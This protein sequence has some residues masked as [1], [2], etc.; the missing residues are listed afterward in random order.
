MTMLVVVLLVGAVSYL[1]RALPLLLV[2]RISLSERTEEALGHAAAAAV[3]A[4]IVG[5]VVHLGDHPNLPAPARWVGLALGAAATAR[6]SM[7]RIMA[8]G[9]LGAWGTALVLHL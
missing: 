4:L 2:D 6:L 1:L 7:V 3:A 9:M 5:L 8:V